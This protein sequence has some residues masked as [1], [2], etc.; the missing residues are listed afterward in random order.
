MLT[1]ICMAL[2]SAAPVDA[3]KAADA[4]KRPRGPQPIAAFIE[5]LAD[6]VDAT[7]EQIEQ[8]EAIADEHD[9][10]LAEQEALTQEQQAEL[11]QLREEHHAAR[12]DGDDKAAEELHAQIQALQGGGRESLRRET[13]EKIA[14]VLTEEQQPIFEEMI[15]SSRPGFG[16]GPRERGPRDRGPRDRGARGDRGPGGRVGMGIHLFIDQLEEKVE[17]TEEQKSQIDAIAV[18]HQKAMTELSKSQ[19]ANREQN[20]EKFED[21][22][23]QLRDARADGDDEQVAAIQKE[24]RELMAGPA[25]E[26]MQGTL[27]KIA[28][29]L[30]PEQTPAFEALVEEMKSRLEQRGP[31]MRPGRGG[32]D[33][34]DSDRPRGRRGRR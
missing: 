8:L 6:A 10:A 16:P 3:E 32:P 17:L 9:A 18:E 14:A 13:H 2:V 19:A 4:P 23:D 34:D 25:K 21:L 20:H 7:P 33:G 26:V 24:M 31:G 5:R 28:A 27:D 29:A 15:A 22:R 11:D 12:M 1:W 30:T